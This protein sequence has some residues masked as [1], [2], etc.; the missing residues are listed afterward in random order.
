MPRNSR[1]MAS[2]YDPCMT[3]VGLARFNGLAA[4]QAAE[5]ALRACCAASAWVTAILAGRPYLDRAGL[6]TRSAEML[7]GLAWI[8]VRQALDA[9]PRIGERVVGEGQE[10]SWSRREQ[11]GMD[12]ASSGVRAALVEANRAY[13]ERFGHVFLIFA[14]G[15]TDVEMLAAARQRV[16]HDE[17]T[18][19]GVVRFELGRIVARRLTVLLDSWGCA[20]G[21]PED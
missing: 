5:Q 20:A 4:D 10:A 7:A 6:L 17:A 11:A 3:D 15:R 16:G 8:E 21:L 9:H 2:A 18:E 19:R 13:E 14:T 12:H 1:A